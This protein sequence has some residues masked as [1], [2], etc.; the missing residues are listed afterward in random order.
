M[1]L[2]DLG[3]IVAASNAGVAGLFAGCSPRRAAEPFGVGAAQTAVDDA[4]PKQPT[5]GTGAG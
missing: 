4:L 3:K 1:R 2:A 5:A